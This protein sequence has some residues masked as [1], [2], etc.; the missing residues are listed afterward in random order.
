VILQERHLK[1]FEVTQFSM[2]ATTT[3]LL[4]SGEFCELRY[5]TVPV[6]SASE[7]VSS[8]TNNSKNAKF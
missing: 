7:N 1:G 6:E 8:Y 4:P 3:Q 2:I 5:G